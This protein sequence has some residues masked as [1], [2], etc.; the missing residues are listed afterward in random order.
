MWIMVEI[1]D[2]CTNAMNDFMTFR[3]NHQK[4]SPE[5]KIT[6]TSSA[7][8]ELAEVTAELQARVLDIQLQ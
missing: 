4:A 7:D 8:G 5:E 6:I 1:P 3:E 2:E